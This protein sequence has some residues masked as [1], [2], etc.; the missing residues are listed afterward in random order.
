MAQKGFKSTSSPSQVPSSQASRAT[1]AQATTQGDRTAIQQ[2]TRTDNPRHH[3]AGVLE[4][5]IGSGVGYRGPARDIPNHA[6][7]VSRTG[8][9]AHMGVSGAGHKFPGRRV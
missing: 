5:S 7:K 4:G 6:A 3:R 1:V 9:H 8:F 2:A